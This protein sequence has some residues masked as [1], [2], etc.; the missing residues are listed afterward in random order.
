MCPGFLF[1]FAASRRKINVILKVINRPAMIGVC[2]EHYTVRR[3]FATL[4]CAG[5]QNI[6]ASRHAVTKPV[7]IDYSQSR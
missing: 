3:N 5:A 2:C 4:L 6:N 1:Y 7:I